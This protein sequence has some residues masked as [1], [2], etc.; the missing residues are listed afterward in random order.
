M[1]FINQ[2]ILLFLSLTLSIVAGAGTLTA[3]VDRTEL[4]LNETF[5]LTVSYDEQVLLDEPDFSELS[6]NFHIVQGPFKQQS[7]RNINGLTESSSNWTLVLQPKVKG[8]F[9]IPVFE[10]DGDKS[11]SLTIKVNAERKPTDIGNDVPLFVELITDKDA[12]YVGEQLLLTYR[13]YL[14][15]GLQNP[16]MTTLELPGVDFEKLH[17]SQFSKVI[18]NQRFQVMELKYAIF[19]TSNG[20]INIPALRF[21]AYLPSS[22]RT[23]FGDLYRNGNRFSALS[24]PREIQVKPQ[25][26]NS[27]SN[28]LPAQNVEL[29]DQWSD[30]SSDWRVGEPITR[31]ITIKAKGA[32]A[33]RIPDIELKES[34]SYTLYPDRPERNQQLDSGGVTGINQQSF[35][36]VPSKPGLL[37]LPKVTLQWWDT[38]KQTLRTASLPERRFNILP[39]SQKSFTPPMPN[40]DV[41]LPPVAESDNQLLWISLSVNGVLLICILWLLFKRPAAQSRQ[42]T[43]T[44][45]PTGNERELFSAIRNAARD[46]NAKQLREAILVWGQT[47]WKN[48]AISTLNEIAER[49]ADSELEKQLMNLDRSLYGQSSDSPDL[50]ALATELKRWR[51][52]GS[53]TAKSEDGLKP[54][55]PQ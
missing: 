24:Q 6:D 47:Y 52:N 3:N 7:Y 37:T 9:T 18:D 31:T 55:Y 45:Q 26:A 15:E 36:I 23:F 48:P 20:T 5:E 21:S 14:A 29:I 30:E 32:T 25:P 12:V 44:E 51:A 10:L 2:A 27:G 28:W 39:A 35:A 46:N 54:L 16:E 19:P 38:A 33:E 41:A 4:S 8:T 53:G 17:Q 49:L 13:I 1:N 43:T 50:T 34:D 11:K 42:T 40:E 22:R